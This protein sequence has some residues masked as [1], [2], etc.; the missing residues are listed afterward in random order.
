M[1]TAQ[2][3]NVFG[4]GGLQ[5]PS[6]LAGTFP[7][8]SNGL[9]CLTGSLT[10]A[11]GGATKVGQLL[12]DGAQYQVSSTTGIL[13]RMIGMDISCTNGTVTPN[14]ILGWAA[15]SFSNGALYSGLTTPLQHAPANT[16]PAD[17][18]STVMTSLSTARTSYYLSAI[19]GLNFGNNSFP[20]W[21]TDVADGFAV[22]IW[23]YE[24]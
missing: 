2:V 3:N 22:K 6:F 10:G 16:G 13:F 21:Q 15:A 5:N 14:I 24:A 8:G 1:S 18:N 4:F 19:A 9:I 12:K 17:G 7:I 20:F 11:Q 23:G